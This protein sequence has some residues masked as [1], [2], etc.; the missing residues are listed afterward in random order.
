MICFLLILKSRSGCQLLLLV[1]SESCRHSH[2]TKGNA[3]VSHCTCSFLDRRVLDESPCRGVGSVTPYSWFIWEFLLVWLPAY[4]LCGSCWECVPGNASYLHF[5]KHSAVSSNCSNVVSIFR[6]FYL[7]SASSLRIL[8]R[9]CLR[10]WKAPS[11]PHVWMYEYLHTVDQINS[12]IAPWKPSKFHFLQSR[13]SVGFPAPISF[14]G[15][16]WE[17]CQSLGFLNL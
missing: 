8:L 16:S 14:C 2:Y 7:M 9:H 5:K 15:V 11:L 3:L 1:E 6:N 10:D 12:Q 13:G 4:R 17:C